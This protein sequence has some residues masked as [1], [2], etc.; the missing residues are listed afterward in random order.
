MVPKNLEAPYGA[1]VVA[2]IGFA[3]DDVHDIAVDLEQLFLEYC[4]SAGDEAFDEIPGI[5]QKAKAR[6]D[7]GE[8]APDR[9]RIVATRL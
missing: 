1:K 7:A 5:W 6:L 2:A 4:W 9:E 8:P 3:A